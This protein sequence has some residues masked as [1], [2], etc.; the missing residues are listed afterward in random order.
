MTE[1]QEIKEGK[2]IK[3]TKVK[4]KGY[5]PLLGLF[6]RGSKRYFAFSVIFAVLVT[7]LEMIN[8]Q[9]IRYTVDAVLGRETEELP[10][11]VNA[12][13]QFFG[14]IEVLRENLWMVAVAVAVVAFFA[15]SCRYF[16]RLFN[17]MGAESLVRTMRRCLYAKIQRLPFAWH[18]KHQTGDI[19]QRCTSD[20][21]MVKNFLSEQLTSI[22]RIVAL[23]T[24]SLYF[25]FTM[26]PSLMLVSLISIPVIVGYSAFFHRHIGARFRECDENEGKLSA[27]A[28]ENLT[29]VRVVRAFGREKYEQERFARQNTY[30]TSLWQ[31]LTRLMAL[32][33]SVG[34][35]MAGI[36]TMLII[37]LGTLQ[38]VNGSMTAGS[39]IAFLS[40]NGMIVWPVRRLGRMISEMSKAGI[41]I[42]RLQEIMDSEEEQDRPDAIC[43]DLNGDIVFD[44]VSFAYDRCPELLYDISFT[45]K[46]GTTVGILGATGSGKSTLL[47]LLN[48]LYELPENS[49][50]ITIGGNNIADISLPWLRSHIGMVLQEPYLFS[51]TLG[52]NITISAALQEDEALRHA[53]RIA[54]LEETVHHFSSGYETMVGER[55]VTLSGGQKQRVAIARMLMQKTPIMVF[56]DSL[57]AVDA[58]TDAK[59]RAGLKE[60]LADATVFLVS[61]RVSTLASADRII[62]L[63]HGRIAETGTYEELMHLENGIFR[64]ISEIQLQASEENTI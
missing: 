1:N 41:S 52:E 17:T 37:V 15:V 45:V 31:K 19:I 10:S 58:E 13:I 7:F 48:R 35:L 20:V 27:I 21:D 49:G 32:F 44:H 56:D 8:P 36:Q 23:I 63:D 62:V 29:G 3:N 12:V 47:H 5:L 18:M 55:G 9:I 16:F 43:P 24:L 30:Y 42:E 11:A 51:R 53:S 59:I 61:H 40:Y 34:D 38:C 6:L 57:S 39:F 28:Q 33:W 22:V 46:A 14:G 60:S 26:S 54:C 2:D 50:S 64:K 25:M 4:K